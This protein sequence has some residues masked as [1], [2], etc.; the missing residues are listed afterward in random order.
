MNRIVSCWQCGADLPD[1]EARFCPACG[2]AL[3]KPTFWEE[4]RDKKGWLWVLLG[5]AVVVAIALVV[6]QV[7]PRPGGEEEVPTVPVVV[8]PTAGV[9]PSP[10]VIAPTDTVAL[11]PTMTTQP[12]LEPT[13]EP[14]PTVDL[15]TLL[16]QA[17]ERFQEAKAYS[18]ATGDTSQL[19]EALAGDALQ[20]QID[21]V[22]QWKAQNC[23]WDITL[24]K[25]LTVKVLETRDDNW[26]RI[27]VAKVETRI[28]KCAGKAD[29]VTAG[30]AYTTNYVVELI[31]GVW[32]ITERE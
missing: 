2:A 1:P 27:E 20:R 31:G 12:T 3:T 23:S 24:D 32:L 13:L 11:A 5:I 19:G 17:A 8:A 7:L 26:A 14:T 9:L 15:D 25:P 28:L 4:F 22:N 10:P 29:S 21:L 30:D 6:T 16:L 18:Q